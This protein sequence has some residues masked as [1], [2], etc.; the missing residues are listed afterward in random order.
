MYC[1]IKKM[2]KRSLMY[3][4]TKKG[5]LGKRGVMQS[6]PSI[7][8]IRLLSTKISPSFWLTSQAVTNQAL[9]RNPTLRYYRKLIQQYHE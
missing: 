5:V 3:A 1:E 7:I 4:K 2:K 9:P 8:A 6:G